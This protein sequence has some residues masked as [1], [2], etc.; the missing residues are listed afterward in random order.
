MVRL[1]E[2]LCQAVDRKIQQ[3]LLTSIRKVP[4]KLFRPFQNPKGGK[5]AK[6]VGNAKTMIAEANGDAGTQWQGRLLGGRLLQI[7]LFP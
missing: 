5:L 6:I 1:C 3:V 7:T 4:C 2:S